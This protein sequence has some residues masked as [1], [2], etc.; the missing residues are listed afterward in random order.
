M[1]KLYRC[2]QQMYLEENSAKYQEA[3]L[4]LAARAISEYP[5]YHAELESAD[6]LIKRGQ[7]Y[8]GLKELKKL[9]DPHPV[10][11]EIVRHRYS[12]L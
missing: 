9:L 12:G 4:A 5:A 8:K 3:Y 11:A 7:H 2:V 1:E 6:R 10:S